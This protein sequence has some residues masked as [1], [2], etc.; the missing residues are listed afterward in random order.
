VLD[1]NCQVQLWNQSCARLCAFADSEVTDPGLC[2]RRR[3]RS[4]E[5]F[6]CRL[7]PQ[8]KSL[9]GSQAECTRVLLSFPVQV[10]GKPLS[11]HTCPSQASGIHEVVKAAAYENQVGT[12]AVISQG[13]CSRAL[14]TKRRVLAA[15]R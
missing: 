1:S 3:V 11:D 7:Q 12:G 5:H 4:A 6:L 13:N 15:R 2:S 14:L 8:G 10:I 9:R